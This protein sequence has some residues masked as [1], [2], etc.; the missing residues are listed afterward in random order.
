MDYKII[1]VCEFSNRFLSISESS[2]SWP[3]GANAHGRTNWNFI[4]FVREIV[5][6]VTSFMDNPWAEKFSLTFWNFVWFR[7]KSGNKCN[8][9]SVSKV[10]SL[11]IVV[12]LP[13]S[14]ILNRVIAEFMSPSQSSPELLAP[15]V[16]QVFEKARR[17]PKEAALVREWILAGLPNF[18]NSADMSRIMWS[19][20]IF[21]I[22]VSSSPEVATLLPF[23]CLRRRTPQ[24]QQLFIH[25]AVDLYGT[26]I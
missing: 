10:L 16:A 12:F 9:Q 1:S 5:V 6:C 26:V 15:V 17:K 13:P 20:A 19:L 24:I 2:R 23:A 14:E 21:F 4:P 22:G 8:S 25:S 18:L 7:L 11:L 3:R